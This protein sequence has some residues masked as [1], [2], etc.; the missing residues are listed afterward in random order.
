MGNFLRMIPYQFCLGFTSLLLAVSAVKEGLD[1]VWK[2]LNHVLG[3]SH[4][5]SKAAASEGIRIAQSPACVTGGT[6]DLPLQA[7]SRTAFP[8]PHLQP[9]CPD[10]GKAAASLALQCVSCMMCCQ[11]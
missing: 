11:S 3:A 5:W 1:L 4:A 9:Q 7:G 10:G 2:I 6:E 8:S